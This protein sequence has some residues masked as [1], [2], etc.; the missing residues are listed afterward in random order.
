[1]VVNLVVDHLLGDN[2][3][4]R[5][6]ESPL[7]PAL[8][9]SL[10]VGIAT[11]TNGGIPTSPQVEFLCWEQLPTKVWFPR[12]HLPDSSTWIADGVTSRVVGFQERQNDTL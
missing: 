4:Y 1:M 10:H 8:S 7:S 11:S 2:G 6:L 9:L 12:T 3:D 5:L